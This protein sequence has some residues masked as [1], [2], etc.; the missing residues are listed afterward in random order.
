VPNVAKTVLILV[1]DEEVDREL[2]MAFIKDE[3]SADANIG[4]IV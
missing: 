3:E 1:A 4:G 2:V